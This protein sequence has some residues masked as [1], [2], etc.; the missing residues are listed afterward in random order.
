MSMKYEIGPPDE[1][2]T[3]VRLWL[4]IT[5]KGHVLLMARKVGLSGKWCVVSLRP[6][7][8]MK[9]HSHLYEGLGFQTDNMGRIKISEED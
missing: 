5:D 9:V 8:T 2:I 1:Q 4:E 3:P 6:E 7:G